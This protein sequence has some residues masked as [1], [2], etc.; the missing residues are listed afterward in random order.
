MDIRFQEAL[1]GE[2][3]MTK[4]NMHMKRW[5]REAIEDHTEPFSAKEIREKVLS[6]RRNSHYITN[7]Y[8]VGW[9]LR[10]ICIKEKKRNGNIYWRKENED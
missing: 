4:T 9:Y 3:R 10:Q 6:G 5:I 8:S 7:E 1:T 2:I